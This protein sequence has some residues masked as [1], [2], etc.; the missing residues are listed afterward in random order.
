MF[1][2][3]TESSYYGQQHRI[4]M[5]VDSYLNTARRFYLAQVSRFFKNPKFFQSQL[6]FSLSFR[7]AWVQLFNHTNFLWR[8][9]FKEV[10][11]TKNELKKYST[12]NLFFI[13]SSWYFYINVYFLAFCIL[14][15]CRFCWIFGKWGKKSA[16]IR[17][18][19]TVQTMI[20]TLE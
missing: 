1:L 5:I 14:G 12:E 3:R 10:S 2:V 11:S 9:Q 16:Y 20:I 8:K 17:K 7:Y 6:S 18:N 4:T 13:L 15:D 19:C